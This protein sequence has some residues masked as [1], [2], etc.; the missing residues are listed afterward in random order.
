M[1][2]PPPPAPAAPE[3]PRPAPSTSHRPGPFYSADPPQCNV[4]PA[5]DQNPAD[6]LAPF[7][8]SILEAR[9][10]L[11]R[12]PRRSAPEFAASPPSLHTSHEFFPPGA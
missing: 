12:F 3:S 4:L 11:T 9:L 2:Q 10:L 6:A 5:R 1:D 8:F 7:D